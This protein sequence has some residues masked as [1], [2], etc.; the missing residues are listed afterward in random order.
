MSEE[1][2]KAQ[3]VDMDMLWVGV[4]D[5]GASRRMGALTRGDNKLMLKSGDPNLEKAA[6]PGRNAQSF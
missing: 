5:V 2:S 4:K 3:R 1:Q 6:K